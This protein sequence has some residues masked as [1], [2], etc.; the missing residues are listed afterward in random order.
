MLVVTASVDMSTLA[1]GGSLL[2]GFK[3]LPHP[4]LWGGD[5]KQVTGLVDLDGVV[6]S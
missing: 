1:K 5:N 6:G 3:L 4:P 2:T